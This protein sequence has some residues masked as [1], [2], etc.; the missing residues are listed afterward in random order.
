MHLIAGQIAP[1]GVGTGTSDLVEESKTSKKDKEKE[2]GKSAGG[3]SFLDLGNTGI[4]KMEST[5]FKLQSFN[6]YTG[7]MFLLVAD[8]F[9][10]DAD[11]ESSLKTL[12]LIYSDYVNKNPFQQ[13]FNL[14]IK[15]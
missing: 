8:P 1:R 14:H 4:L 3:K 11:L 2:K 13:V 5:L 6:S 9:H 12:Y 15:Y 10:S 7:V